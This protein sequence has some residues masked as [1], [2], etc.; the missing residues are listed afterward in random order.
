MKLALRNWLAE[1]CLDALGARGGPLA[2]A[3][4]ALSSGLDETG[5][6]DG[7]GEAERD[8]LLTPGS[9]FE[10]AGRGLRLRAELLPELPGLRD[11]AGRIAR[12]AAA[13]RAR[14]E[15][16]RGEEDDPGRALAAAA[17]L[18]DAGLFFETHEVLEPPWKAADEPLRT[19]LQGLIQIAAGFHHRSQGNLRGA[20]SLLR[21]GL[22]RLHPFSPAAYRVDVRALL[23]AVETA[24]G[25][26]DEEPSEPPRLVVG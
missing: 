13:F 5:T 9:P 15:S 12:A 16:A 8:A 25:A 2:A 1:R 6:V 20:E 3:F 21:E 23:A 14:T 10:P 17:A 18:F 22:A 19:F 24:L 7:V 26:L 4:A 11:R